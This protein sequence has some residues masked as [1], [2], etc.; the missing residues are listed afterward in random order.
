VYT[1]SCASRENAAVHIARVEAAVAPEGEVRVLTVT[2]KQF[3]RMLVFWGK[4]RRRPES[5]PAQLQ[6]F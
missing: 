3:A 1:R 2:D 5:P 6:L 4:T